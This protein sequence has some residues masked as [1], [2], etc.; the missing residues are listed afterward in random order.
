MR[1]FPI[2]RLVACRDHRT[3]VGAFSVYTGEQVRGVVAA[4][5]A[6]GRPLLLQAG[7][8]TFSHLG[9]GLLVAVALAAAEEAAQPIGVHLDHSR[10]LG[11]VAYCLDAGYTSVMVDGSH[12]DLEA[13]VALTARAVAMAH[14]RGAWV[15]G[16]L[17]GTAGDEDR[18]TEAQATA[19]TDPQEAAEFVAATGVDALAVAVGNVH[20]MASR[21]PRLDLDRL[22]AIAA[23]VA[24]PLVLH[25]A[26][27]VDPH[28][29]REA[30]RLGVAKVNVNTELRRAFLHALSR[31]ASASGDALPAA[32]LPAVEATERVCTDW[33][34][35]LADEDDPT[36]S[37]SR[38]TAPPPENGA[39]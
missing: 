7:S 22:A 6:A 19:M 2:E 30:V 18:S 37:N 21:P 11:E 33:V 4:A 1:A 31:S 32:L 14:D 15:E 13:N 9:R 27:G 20:G 12:L 5:E 28:E 10:D 17:T 25:G 29:L 3:A 35:T 23:R 39:A 26:S 8:S 38:R 36:R 24:V 34:R 16:E